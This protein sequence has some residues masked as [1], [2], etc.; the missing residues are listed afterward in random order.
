MKNILE[1][2]ITNGINTG[3]III[4]GV[5][6]ALQT[7]FLIALILVWIIEFKMM[8]LRKEDNSSNY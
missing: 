2:D 3:F 7:F 1:K 8:K 5:I 4:M 6:A